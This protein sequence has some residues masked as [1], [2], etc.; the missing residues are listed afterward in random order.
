MA[1]KDFSMGKFQRRIKRD[2]IDVHKSNEHYFLEIHAEPYFD[3]FRS[4]ET[5]DELLNHL[6][7]YP[8]ENKNKIIKEIR[9]NDRLK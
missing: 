2:E 4:F 1:L 6:K 8:I 7:K 9:K 3:I 5:L